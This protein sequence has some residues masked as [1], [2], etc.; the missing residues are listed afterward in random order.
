MDWRCG[1][2]GTAP[3]LQARSPEFKSHSVPQ[4]Q[5]IFLQKK[6][7]LKFFILEIHSSVT[8]LF[9][10]KSETIK[11]KTVRNHSLGEAH[12]VSWYFL[13][14]HKTELPGNKAGVISFSTQRK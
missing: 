4:P 9:T 1:S 6:I 7:K 10:F 2:S 14:S 8:L 11:H 13:S 5:K 12:V 3:P